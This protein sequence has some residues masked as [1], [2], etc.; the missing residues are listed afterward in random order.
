MC[1]RHGSELG[2]KSTLR[3]YSG[4]VEILGKERKA[5]G[6]DYFEEIGV[7]FDFPNLYIKLTAM[8]NLELAASYYSC[9]DALLLD[10]PSYHQ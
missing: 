8:E 2:G 5:W 3:H 10:R 1:A 9:F 6:K 4:S 7:A